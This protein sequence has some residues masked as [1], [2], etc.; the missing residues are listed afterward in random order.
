MSDILAEA[1]SH[2]LDFLSLKEIFHEWNLLV[3]IT[4]IKVSSF[5]Y[6]HNNISKNMLASNFVAF[7]IVRNNDDDNDVNLRNKLSIA[8]TIDVTWIQYTQNQS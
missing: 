2:L 6:M 7:N 3:K 1:K 5:I 4:C 8:S